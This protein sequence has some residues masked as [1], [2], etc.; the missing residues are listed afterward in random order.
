MRRKSVLFLYVI[1]ILLLSNCR[2][3][4][5]WTLQTDDTRL[6]ICINSND[7]LCIS[8]L[9]NQSYGCNWAGPETI[10]RLTDSVSMDSISYKMHWIYKKGDIDYSD[11]TKLTLVFAN[12]SPAIELK[13]VWHARKGKGPIRHTMFI[14]NNCGKTLTIY[15]QESLYL[16]LIT[17]EEN[18]KVWYINDDGSSPD[19]VGV[20]KDLLSDGYRKSLRISE[21][22]KDWIPFVVLD[23]N[24]SHGLYIGWEWSI[25]RID[26]DKKHDRGGTLLMAGNGD[27][28]RTDLIEGETFEIPPAFI[29]TYKGDI[30]DCG[31][32]LRKYLFNYSM[33]AVLRN[34]EGFPRVEWNAFAA[35]GKKQ[36]SWDCVESKYYPLID[37]IAPLGF[38]D[39]VIDVGWWS[40]KIN[41]NPYTGEE[42]WTHKDPFHYIADPVDW[43]SG[44]SAASEYAHERGMRFGLYSWIKPEYVLCDTGK[45]KIISELSY[46]FN[47]LKADF[48]RSDNI[49]IFSGNT[50]PNAYGKGQFAHY[51][52]DVG[53]WSTKGYYEVIDS[54]YSKIDRFYWE[55]CSNGGRLKDYGTLKR[56]VRIQNQDTYYPINARQ[57]FYDASYALHPMQISALTGS[58]SVWQASGSVYE[59]RCSSMGSAVWHPDAPNGGNGGPVWTERQKDEIKKAVLTYKTKIRP[60][61]RN[62]NLYHIF[63]RPDDIVWDGIEYFDPLMQKGVVYIFKPKSTVNTQSIKLKGLD[64]DSVYKITFEDKTNANIILKGGDLM[65]SGIE[66]TLN[67][68]YISELMFIE[69]K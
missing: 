54:M 52:E 43:P 24:S 13:S 45:N 59:F 44:M 68:E 64:G 5:T 36:G 26:I 50:I 19:S 12:E 9:A 49:I 42:P 15:E 30:D 7:E 33:P 10:F 58:W 62:G 4:N 34:D 63:P 40:D 67:G 61:I 22:A 69:K 35:T 25:G 56:A 51:P 47:D 31:N 2:N 57:S 23:A 1:S 48:Y 18:T 11:G 8:E 17:P 21:D 32:S 29:G 39:I 46:L 3:N 6:V 14:T 16:N 55:N 65:N 41:K 27:N 37:D 60:L 38:E 53:Y 66:V 20:Y 28:F